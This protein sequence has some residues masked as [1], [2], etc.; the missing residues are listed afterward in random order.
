M[1]AYFNKT[2]YEDSLH[3]SIN[4]LPKTLFWERR[5]NKNKIQL[6][7]NE[8]FELKQNRTRGAF[9]ETRWSFTGMIRQF[10]SLLDI[11]FIQALVISKTTCKLN[12]YHSYNILAWNPVVPKKLKIIKYLKIK[13]KY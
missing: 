12:I 10:T 11:P 3:L 8:L 1:V 2:Q 4:N 6:V 5:E 7:I 9:G 13:M